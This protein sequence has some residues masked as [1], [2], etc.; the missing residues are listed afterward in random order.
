VD[1]ETA[2]VADTIGSTGFGIT[3]GRRGGGRRGR[4]AAGV[5]RR[6]GR[7]AGGAA[8]RGRGAVRRGAR[9]GGG[10]RRR[11]GAAAVAASPARAGA[12]RVGAARGASCRAAAHAIPSPTAKRDEQR[13]WFSHR[14]RSPSISCMRRSQ[15]LIGVHIGREL[16]DGFILRGAVRL[17]EH[18]DHVD[19]ALVMLD[20]ALEEQAIELGPARLSSAAISSSVSMPGINISWTLPPI[21][22]LWRVDVASGTSSPRSASHSRIIAISSRCADDDALAEDRDIGRAPCVGAQPAMTTACA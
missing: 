20:H 22:I 11:R 19:R 21:F 7:A 8:P 18:V 9:G 2:P 5:R 6:R 16:E 12:G 1:R 17:E 3:A 14:F 4:A 13:E 10:V 15:S